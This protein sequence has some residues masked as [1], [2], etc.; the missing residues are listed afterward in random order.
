[1]SAVG[2]RRAFRGFDWRLAPLQRKLEWEVEAARTSLA[3]AQS[4][5]QEA[6]EALRA[7]EV[8][9]R[10]ASEEARGSAAVHSDPRAHRQLLSWLVGLGDQV[11]VA[12]A[13]QVE[14][15]ERLSAA[16]QDLLKRQRRLD[17]L[18]RA[19]DGALAAHVRDAAR[20]EQAEADAAWLALRIARQAR[21]GMEEQ[22]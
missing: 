16:R 9:L 14:A 13:K 3:K 8:R 7:A 20:R 4:G 15:A 21:G 11:A 6:D 19:R 12:A 18:L 17:V 2:Q 1:M 22:A 5:T 10:Q